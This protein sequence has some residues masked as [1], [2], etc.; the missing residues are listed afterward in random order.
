MPS[1]T[2]ALSADALTAFGTLALAFLTLATL[3]T[4]VVITWR[5]N[6]QLRAE[7][8]AAQQRDSLAEAYAVE[9]TGVATTVLINHGRYTI[10]AIAAKLRTKGGVLLDF[11]KA[12]RLLG[13]AGTAADLGA[14]S[15]LEAMFQ[16]DILTPWDAA[17]RF[18]IRP[19]DISDLVG[20]YPVVRWTDRSGTRWQHQQ[21]TVACI[22]AAA[23]WPVTSDCQ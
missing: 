23:P 12:E 6:R 10:S 17:L 14:D 15:A 13:T 5:G 11:E 20:A 22:D 1:V 21:G 16:P 7:R 3:V 9:V 4:T 19:E 18:T 8:K 2:F